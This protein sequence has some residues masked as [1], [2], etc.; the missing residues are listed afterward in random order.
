MLNSLRIGIALAAGLLLLGAAPP[1]GACITCAV[2]EQNT[3]DGGSGVTT[4]DGREPIGPCSTPPTEAECREAWNDSSAQSTCR[5]PPE[6]H[7]DGSHYCSISATCSSDAV[8]AF[9]SVTGITECVD[10]ISNVSNCDGTL[11]VGSC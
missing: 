3:G 4:A 6:I 5:N 11:R 10:D 1:A 9:W 7:I 8:S 2:T